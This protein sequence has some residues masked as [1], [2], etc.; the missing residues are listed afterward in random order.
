MTGTLRELSDFRF[1]NGKTIVPLRFAPAQSWFVVFRKKAAQPQELRPNF[2]ELQHVDELT[3]PWDVGFDPKWGGPAE[4]KF[5]KLEDWTKRPEPGIRY[6]SGT[7]TYR[8]VFS[9]PESEIS[10]LKSRIFLS[11]GIVNHIARVRLNGRD[12]GVVWCAPWG[13]EIPA[14]LLK[15]TGNE[16]EIEVTNVW[17]NRLIGDEQEPPDCEWLPGHHF[18]DQGGYLK[19]FP[20]WFVKKEPRPSKGR[21]C[22]VT[23][24]YFTKDSP[25]I[26]SGLLGPVTIMS[27]TLK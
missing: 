19:R 25:L 10:N 8:K 1:E 15:P 23:W 18:A 17:A 26:P 21:Y 12:L 24:N 13:V 4:V 14:G 5:D 6:Y 20:D 11:L 22:F 27:P 7:A 3:G 2:P 9:L 16:L